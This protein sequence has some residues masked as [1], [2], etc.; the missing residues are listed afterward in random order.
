MKNGKCP[1]CGS[2]SVYTQ[3]NELQET[4]VSGRLQV[5]DDYVCA[6]CGCFE[7]YLTD[8]DALRKI[9]ERWKKVTPTS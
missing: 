2:T 4:R 8:K 5:V 3:Q 7:T 9:A 1:K 6:A